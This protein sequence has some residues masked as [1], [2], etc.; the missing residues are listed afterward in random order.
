MMKV[1]ESPEI[2][3]Q[4]EPRNGCGG[5][6]GGRH[7]YIAVVR[8]NTEKAT[9]QHLEDD[10]FEAYVATQ[11]ETRHYKCG[12][13][14]QIERVVIPSC[15]FVHATDDERLQ[16]LKR[17]SFIA[18]YMVNRAAAPG[19]YGRQPL[20]VITDQQMEQMR[21]MLYHSPNP[22]TFTDVAMHEG[23]PIR[24]TRGPL[25]GQEGTFLSLRGKDTIAIYL[26][27]L[28]TISVQISREDVVA[29]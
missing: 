16:S 26:P 4:S 20:A 7:W 14:K 23:D 25:K 11:T 9:R 27:S 1:A 8:H 3:A 24:V 5:A 12:H 2:A 21:Y 10:G 17:C 19:P 18:F 13:K 29:I 22:V 28:G 15:V 6:V